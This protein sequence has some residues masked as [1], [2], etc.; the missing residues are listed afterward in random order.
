MRNACIVVSTPFQ[1]LSACAI[2][3]QFKD[4]IFDLYIIGNFNKFRELAEK[5]KK[6]KIYRNVI[7][8]EL[9]DIR[10]NN[11]SNN[12]FKKKIGALFSYFSFKRIEKIVDSNAKY[13]AVFFAA[14]HSALEFLFYVKSKFNPVFYM[15]DDGVRTYRNGKHF[16]AEN[17]SSGKVKRL[18][19]KIH[20]SI[21]PTLLL[22]MPELFIKLNGDKFEIEKLVP[23]SGEKKKIV[24]DLGTMLVLLKR[25]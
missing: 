10:K 3:E 14:A 7:S 21:L 17:G 9:S 19:E 4:Y 11:R 6:T 15:F 8:Y 20:G 13:E 2:T 5:L 25:H 23:L 18:L 22:Y 1:A 24:E 16:L 12:P